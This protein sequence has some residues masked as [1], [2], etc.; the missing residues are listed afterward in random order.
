[1]SSRPLLLLCL[2]LGAA[3]ASRRERKPNLRHLVVSA[4]ELPSEALDAL[5][6]TPRESVIRM[7]RRGATVSLDLST[8]KKSFELEA[9][10]SCPLSLDANNLPSHVRLEPRI[11]ITGPSEDVG[12]DAPFELAL[13]TLCGEAGGPRG[14]VVWETH[15]GPLRAVSTLD[16][17]Y[18]VSARTESAPRRIAEA[19][20]GEIVPISPN[21]RGLTTLT[22]HWTGADG[23][24]SQRTVT[25]SAAPRS[26][27]LPN[28]AL[29]ERTLLGGKGFRIVARPPASQAEPSPFGSLTSIVPDARGLFELASGETHVRLLVGSYDSVPLDCGRAE[30]HAA[31][32]HAA[33]NSPM[34]ATK[35]GWR[36]TLKAGDVLSVHTTYDTRKASWYEAMGIS[37][38]FFTGSALPGAAD[39]FGGVDWHGLLTHGHLAENDHHGGGPVSFPDAR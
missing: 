24:V 10:G 30:C 26:R 27:G 31:A 33:E 20:L 4:P 39:P 35:P 6:V 5:R 38:V 23:S 17:G 16:Q 14:T 29:G 28:V 19:R 13:R 9:P 18:R 37:V 11:E 25:V 36:V 3:C 34:T 32:A 15:G 8:T 12:Y 22:A 21:E 2:V 1:M 7:E